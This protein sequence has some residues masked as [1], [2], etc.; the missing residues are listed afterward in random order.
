MKIISEPHTDQYWQ[1]IPKDCVNIIHSFL[2]RVKS[3]SKAHGR[4]VLRKTMFCGI[5][6]NM[7]DNPA[8]IDI[9][10]FDVEMQWMRYGKFYRSDNKP[11]QIIRKNGVISLRW[12]PNRSIHDMPYSIDWD[13]HQ[14][15]EIRVTDIVQFCQDN[16]S[17][18][19][20]VQ[21]VDQIWSKY[22]IRTCD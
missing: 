12:L 22:K 4:M 3:S 15:L 1:T 13:S 5:L 19:S 20:C 18:V 6:H 16:P 17:L 10:K 11:N 14:Y 9:Y 21:E 8:V 7:D 2:Y